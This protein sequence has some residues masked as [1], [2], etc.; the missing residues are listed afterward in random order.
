M[1][2]TYGRRMSSGYCVVSTKY[3]S[4]R[5]MYFLYEVFNHIVDFSRHIHADYC[6]ARFSEP[7]CCVTKVSM[8]EA[9]HKMP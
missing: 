4:L 3:F 2:M 5:R 6:F 7:G 1:T 8:I 9:G